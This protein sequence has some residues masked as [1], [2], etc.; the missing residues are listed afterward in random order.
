MSAPKSDADRH[1]QISVKSIAGVAEVSE[2][3]RSF[4]RHLHYTQ[5][6]DRNVATARDYYTALAHTVRDY[7]GGRWIRTQQRYYEQDPKR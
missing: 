7:L 5:V 6:K 3:K 4:N 1:R 2:V